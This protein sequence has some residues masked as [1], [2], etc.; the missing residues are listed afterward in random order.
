[1][2][3]GNERNHGTSLAEATPHGGNKAETTETG[4][5]MAVK[6]NCHHPFLIGSPVPSLAFIAPAGLLANQVGSHRSR[7]N[8]S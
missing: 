3:N 6:G 1:M 5:P 7:T 8:S 2:A 4:L